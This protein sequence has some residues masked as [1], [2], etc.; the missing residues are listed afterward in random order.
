MTN[1]ENAD[2]FCKEWLEGKSIFTVKTSGST[3]EPKVIEL[4]REQ[5]IASA[6]K[7]IKALDLQHGMTALVCLDVNFIAGRMMLVRCLVA[8]MNMIVVEPKADPFEDLGDVRIDFA[9]LVPYQLSA[10]LNS[11]R[12]LRNVGKVILGGA[13]LTSN[14]REKVKS[15][16]HV[17]FYATFGMTE[18][19]TH[20]ALQQLNS[21][22][23]KGAQQHFQTLKGVEVNV[24]ERGCLVIDADHLD[25][26]IVTNDLVEIISPH[27][28][29]WIGRFDNVINSGGIKISPELIETE[30][31]KFLD[32]QQIHNSLFVTGAPH[33]Q[34]GEQVTLV[35]EGLIDQKTEQSLLDHLKNVLHRYEVPKQV[36][37]AH[38]FSMTLTGKVN[39]RLSL[40]NA[41][42][43]PSGR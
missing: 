29:K 21:N 1:K 39:R 41:L 14:L 25:G 18:T 33:E 17:T 5:M 12:Q 4:R 42:P 26:T 7:T 37:Y 23:G 8:G 24:D 43:R 38:Q 10:V 40:R 16:N 32:V 9:A 11:S 19:I 20:I 15:L 34:L 35:I 3:G 22:N 27:E 31:S 13:P 30:A 28:F 6:R 2:L 36:L